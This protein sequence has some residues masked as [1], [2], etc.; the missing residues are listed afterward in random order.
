M[1]NSNIESSLKRFLKRKIK[2]TMGLIISFLITGTVGFIVEDKVAAGKEESY[3]IIEEDGT[4]KIIGGWN[5]TENLTENKDHSAST[6][7]ITLVSGEVDELIGGN[8]IK[9]VKSTGTYLYGI[10]NTNVIMKD[11][12]VQYLIGG[13]KS[14]GTNANITNR[15][16]KIT[17][18]EGIIGKADSNGVTKAGLIGGN[19]IKSTSGQGGD[20][21]ASIAGGTQ[22]TIKGGTFNNR[23]IGGSFVD[24]YGTT[25]SGMSVVDDTTD[26]NITGGTF[27]DIVIGGGAAAGTGNTSTVETSNLVITGGVFNSNIYAGGAALEAIKGKN[28]IGTINVVNS[29]LMID[30]SN[31]TGENLKF[32]FTVNNGGSIFAGGLNS[33]VSNT[34]K[35]TLKNLNREVFKANLDL[36]GGSR[37]TAGNSIKDGNIEIDIFN[38]S[39]NGGDFYAGGE[40]DGLGAKVTTGKSILILNNFSGGKRIFGAGGSKNGGILEQESTDIKLNNVTGEQ[41]YGGGWAL[42]NDSESDGY[43]KIETTKIEINGDSYFNQVFGGS[44]ISR[45]GNQGIVSTGKTNIIVNNGE[46]TGCVVGGNFSNWFGYSVMGIESENGSYEFNGKKYNAGSTNVTIN[47]GNLSEAHILGGNYVE[48]LSSQY[49]EYQRKAIVFG[50]TN[51]NVTG[52]KL[53]LVVGGGEA[54]FWNGSGNDPATES[55]VEGTTNINITGGELLENIIGGGYA[56]QE[57]EVSGSIANVKGTTNINI[58]G[59]IIEKDIYG[60]G[61]ADGAGAVANVEGDTNIIISGG[62]IQGDIYAGGLSKDGGTAEVTGKST[63]TFLDGSTFANKVQGTANTSTLAFGN[64]DKQF[65]GEFRGEF[66]DFSIINTGKNSIVKINELNSSNVNQDMEFTGAGRIETSINSIGGNISLSSGTLAADKVNLGDKKLTLSG[67]GILETKSGNIFTNALD[68]EATEVKESGEV[69]NNSIEYNGGSIAL[70]DSK[71]NLDYLNSAI[72]V[73]KNKS[74]SKDKTTLLMLGTLVNT[75]GEVQE[76]IS[77][78][79]AAGVGN[80]AILDNVV[81]KVDE[82]NSSLVIGGDTEVGD[83]KVN[84]GF[85]ASTLDFKDEEDNKSIIID[86]DSK[87]VLGGSRDGELVTVGG[88]AAENTNINIKEGTLVLGSELSSTA[89]QTLSAKIQV[90]TDSNSGKLE[91]NAGNQTVTGK[92]TNNESGTMNQQEN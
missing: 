88:K 3:S 50:D 46:I 14:N 61:Y 33:G 48:H 78:D 90:G 40:A 74:Q 20:I 52:G 91:V 47:D 37:A 62:N 55:N 13:S 2:I 45:V 75:G 87:V 65:N 51:I 10:G 80:G 34:I 30:G 81:V 36:H 8:H 54:A 84:N 73:M 67:K 82:G 59:G 17:V 41:L 23:V 24:T 39:L 16:A 12:K 68:T 70:S 31:P 19:Y 15:A 35:L 4:P 85:N 89:N 7:N 5:Y 6:S 26:V 29:N 69:K 32:N 38:S 42:N 64:A 76:D 57:N 49:N 27:N 53:G 44:I 1:K 9:N 28:D 58:S 18:N 43:I 72:T 77:V 56:F 11:G 83:K 79:T 86:G 22:V 60:G 63:V 66:S 92:I 25:V 71:Y 21:T